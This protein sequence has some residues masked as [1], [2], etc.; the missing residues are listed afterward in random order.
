MSLTQRI[1]IAMGVGV[2]LGALLQWLAL[3]QDHLFNA[4]VL[5]G[6]ID[7]GGRIF[8]AL[9]KML[10][11][12]LVF[13]SLVC[14]AASLG[15]TGSVGRLGGKTIGL[16]LMTTAVAVSLAMLIALTT[17]PGLG[18][19][20]ASSMASASTFEPKTAPS[21][22][23]TFINVVPS[24]PIAAMADGKM[25]QV[26]LFALLFG[27]ALSKAR[28]SGEKLRAF[29]SDLNDVM[30]RLISMI[31]ALTP[32]GVFCLMTQLGATLG[33]A[34]IAKVAMYFATIVI[35]LLVH[36]SLVYPLLLKTLTGLNPLVFL[37]K[38]R[39]ALLVAF[40]TSSSG[41]TLPVTLRTVEHKLGVQNNVASFAV[42]LGATINM[43]GTAI[44]QGVATVFIAQFYG[45]DLGLS[46]LLTVVLTA[47]LASIGTAAVPGVGLITLTLVLD[48]VGLPVEGIA[49]IIGVDRLLDMLRTAVNVTGDATVATIVAS[50]EGQLDR[51][52]F[53]A[54]EAQTAS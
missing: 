2:G 49:L 20:S 1:L 53:S 32:I 30:M 51:E 33:L 43:D 15:D 11:V 16:Y 48:Q 41:A 54:S 36:A 4:V 46:A 7:G 12:P 13:V 6:F 18:G 5:N 14:G 3:P 38:M 29:F 40:S 25:L 44:M 28:A 17:D 52:V 26:I 21:V 37:R 22:K 34:E 42:P 45:I 31:I 24:N 27:L 50:S 19:E 39:E 8:I 35:A 10:V 9:L 23:D 47:T